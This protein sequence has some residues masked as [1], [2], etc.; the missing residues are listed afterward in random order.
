M[1]LSR[2]VSGSPVEIYSPWQQAADA[3][4][5]AERLIADIPAF[6][7]YDLAPET[8]L[9]LRA[10]AVLVKRAARYLH[11]AAAREAPRLEAIAADFEARGVLPPWHRETSEEG[12]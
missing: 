12:D 7:G 4:H 9:D 6:D 3:I 11:A 10:A 1:S 8:D 2:A 5:H